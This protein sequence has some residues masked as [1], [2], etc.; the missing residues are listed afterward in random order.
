MRWDAFQQEALQALGFQVLQMHDSATQSQSQS[1]SQTPAPAM[2]TWLAA[3]L[4]L[5]V[6]RLESARLQWPSPE[7]VR[8]PLIKRKL[9][10]HLRALYRTP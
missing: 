6:E 10:P 9:W 1:Q 2:L 7:A 5:P 4:R 3:A 8:D